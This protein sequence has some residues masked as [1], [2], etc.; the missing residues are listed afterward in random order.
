MSRRHDYV[1]SIEA[2]PKACLEDSLDALCIVK[3]MR[4]KRIQVA[5]RL[6]EAGLEVGLGEIS[7][8]KR[9]QKHIIP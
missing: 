3:C 5:S 2:L 8:V 4:N 7:I 6:I 1:D 9:M